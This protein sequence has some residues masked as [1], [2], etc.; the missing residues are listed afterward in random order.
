MVHIT[1]MLTIPKTKSELKP[2][3]DEMYL[4]AM[5]PIPII[6]GNRSTRDNKI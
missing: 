5:C 1:L 3:Q 4:D 6:T 2:F